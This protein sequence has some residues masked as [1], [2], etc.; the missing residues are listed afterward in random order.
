MRRI[1]KEMHYHGCTLD[2]V[3]EAIAKGAMPKVVARIEDG[4][5]K[6]VVCDFLCQTVEC[7]DDNRVDHT[8]YFDWSEIDS[9]KEWIDEEYQGGYYV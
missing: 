3:K 6:M 4:R 7:V 1:V 2:D 9:I 8:W 5:P